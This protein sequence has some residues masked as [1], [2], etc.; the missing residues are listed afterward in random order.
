MSTDRNQSETGTP[1]TQFLLQDL[2]RGLSVW[3]AS[4]P[5]A[6]HVIRTIFGSRTVAA[7]TGEN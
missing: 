3:F 1:A 6:R 2:S 5:D 4:R 7:K